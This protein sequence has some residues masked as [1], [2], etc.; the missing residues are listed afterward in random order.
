MTGES[1]GGRLAGQ[2]SPSAGED[3]DCPATGEE[4]DRAAEATDEAEFTPH[5]GF[6]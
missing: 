6:L 4:V 3:Q 1:C 2:A 5:P